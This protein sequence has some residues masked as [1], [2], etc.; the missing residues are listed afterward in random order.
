V[1]TGLRVGKPV[2]LEEY[3]VRAADVESRDAVYAA[4]LGAVREYSGAGDLVWMIAGEVDGSRYPD[5]DGFTL[6]TVADAQ[7]I[8]EHINS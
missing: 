8:V 1:R 7:V 5:Y 2:L 3:G 4:W 6:Y